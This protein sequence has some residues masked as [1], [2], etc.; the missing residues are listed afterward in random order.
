M[1]SGSAYDSGQM[2]NGQLTNQLA[3]G[4]TA[5]W[6]EPESS[7]RYQQQQQKG[8]DQPVAV[9]VMTNGTRAPSERSDNYVQP[10]A[11]NQP[12]SPSHLAFLY[13]RAQQ[14]QP[15]KSPSTGTAVFA[16]GY[17]GMTSPSSPPSDGYRSLSRA[18]PA[19]VRHHHQQPASTAAR[20]STDASPEYNPLSR[21]TPAPI[22]QHAAQS[23]TTTTSADT[24]TP[25]S[26]PTTQH[27][28]S[29]PLAAQVTSALAGNVRAVQPS[30]C[31]VLLIIFF[32]SLPIATRVV[33]GRR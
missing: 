33:E 5:N 17:A 4:P 10:F 22:Q 26:P 2:D 20:T 16:N 30:I 31:L 8:D 3:V 32:A 14:P 18:V 6:L 24:G 15:V 12:T 19:P 25:S 28:D 11:G 13:D 7:H 29:H 23:P 27:G 9:R 1:Y 21:A